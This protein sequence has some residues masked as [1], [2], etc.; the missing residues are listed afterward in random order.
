MLA[1]R[2]VLVSIV[3]NCLFNVTIQ[4]AIESKELEE[5][6][7]IHTVKRSQLIDDMNTCIDACSECLQ[8]DLLNADVCR[9]R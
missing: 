4:K 5:K 1:I 3:L 6:K 9:F 8:D 7:A 2:F